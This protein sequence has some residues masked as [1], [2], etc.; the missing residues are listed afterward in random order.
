MRS[1]YQTPGLSVPAKTRT[2]PRRTK[3][4]LFAGML[5]DRRLIGETESAREVDYSKR[6]HQTLK[7]EGFGGFA[8]RA[9]TRAKAT[10]GADSRSSARV[11]VCVK[12]TNRG[13]SNKQRDQVH[14][15][16]RMA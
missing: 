2:A 7:I 15:R 13:V 10:G 4:R 12:E 16:I 11:N 14:L 9:G 3:I 5:R 8:P 1:K 6:T